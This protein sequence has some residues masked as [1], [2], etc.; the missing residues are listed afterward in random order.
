MLLTLSLS[1]EFSAYTRLPKGSYLVM[2]DCEDA[3]GLSCWLNLGNV[4]FIMARRKDRLISSWKLEKATVT[5]LEIAHR[6]QFKYCMELNGI[7]TSHIRT[8][9]NLLEQRLSRV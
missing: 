3:A 5:V 8:D 9:F 1:K 7:N 4:P 2:L 6:Y